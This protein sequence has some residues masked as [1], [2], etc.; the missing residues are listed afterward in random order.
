ML[1]SDIDAAVVLKMVAA[2][3]RHFYYRTEKNTAIVTF[4]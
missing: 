3:G 2:S 1:E 4:V